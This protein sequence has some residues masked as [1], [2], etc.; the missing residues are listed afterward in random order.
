MGSL[1]TRVRVLGVPV[2]AIGSDELIEEVA[3]SVRSRSRLL[4]LSQNLHGI[5]SYLHSRDFE[6]LHESANT[7]IHMDGTSMALMAKLLGHDATLSHR[8][9]VIQWIGR[10]LSIAS[11]NEWRVFHL[12]GDA[13]LL[14][15]ALGLL[16]EQYQG[17]VFGGSH[18]FFELDHSGSENMQRLR[19]IENFS[20]DVLLVGMGM[21]RQEAWILQNRDR[22]VAPVIVTV[23]SVLRLVTGELRTAPKWISQL[24]FEWLF[25]FAQEPKST[26]RRYFLEPIE[27]CA[28]LIRLRGML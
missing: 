1:E 9:G 14:S 28:R 5:H 7:I 2:D 25:R 15:G 3:A 22:I 27:I 12:G 20:P 17:A 16:Q 10:L 8:T 6:L 18:G 11:D 24:G 4:V 21:P 23:G 19:E 26:A 13:Q